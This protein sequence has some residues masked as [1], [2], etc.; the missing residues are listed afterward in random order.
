MRCILLLLDG[1]GD[2]SHPVLNGLT[3]LQAAHTPNLDRIAENGM[4]GLFHAHLQGTALPSELAHFLMFGYRI[5]EF[6]GRGALEAL[7]EGLDIREDDVALLARIFSVS[8]ENKTL[9]LR[10]ENPK[11]DRE[12]CRILHEAVGSFR[13]NGI[14]AEFFPTKGIGGILLLRGNVSSAVTDSNPIKI[15]RASCRERVC[16]YV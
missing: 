3:P 16:Q 8:E 7:G 2:R 1:L 5:E 14:D 6:P 4:N 12:S 10:H 9:I 11:L 15:G 13:W